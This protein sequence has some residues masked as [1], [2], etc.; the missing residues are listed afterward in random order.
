[1][2]ITVL[3]GLTFYGMVHIRRIIK[4]QLFNMM[5]NFKCKV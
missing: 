2:L 1:M 4:K 3:G 5:L